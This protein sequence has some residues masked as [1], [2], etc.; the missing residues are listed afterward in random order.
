M[1][2]PSFRRPKGG[3]ILAMGGFSN[4]AEIFPTP[5][6]D[7]HPFRASQRNENALANCAAQL[8]SLLGHF[9]HKIFHADQKVLTLAQVLR[10]AV[11]QL[12]C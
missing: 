10:Q 5:R 4:P 9:I 11:P 3:R 6:N 12:F 2:S 8:A 1:E 7:H